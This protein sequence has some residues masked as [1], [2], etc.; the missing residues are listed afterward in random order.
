VEHGQQR[1]MAAAVE[2][3]TCS[4]RGASERGWI[5]CARAP[6]RCGGAILVPGLAGDGVEGGRRR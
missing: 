3:C 4:R 1:E 6:W 2:A 5:R